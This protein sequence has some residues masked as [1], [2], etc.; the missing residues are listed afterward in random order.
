MTCLGRELKNTIIVDNSPHSYIFQPF[1][2]VPIRNFIDDMTERARMNVC[3]YQGNSNAH[4]R[5]RTWACLRLIRFICGC[6]LLR[7]RSLRQ[8][9]CWAAPALCLAQDLLDLLPKLLQLAEA[10]DVTRIIRQ[11]YLSNVSP[12][13]VR[14]PSS[15]PG[16]PGP[17]R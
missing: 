2:A 15:P 6:L 4:S 11:T 17:R 8:A 14:P 16:S 13:Y 12:I 3:P 10:D 9:T 7:M 5:G 1:N